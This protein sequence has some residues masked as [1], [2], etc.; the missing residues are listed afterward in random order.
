MWSTAVVFKRDARIDPKVAVHGRE[1]VL[2][3]LWVIVRFASERIRASNDATALDAAT[4]KRRT[5]NIGPVIA[6]ALGVDLRG[7]PEFAPCNDHR[8]VDHA[9]VVKILDER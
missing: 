1:D 2:G 8:S 4:R 6:A 9:A 3:R 5:E 7:S